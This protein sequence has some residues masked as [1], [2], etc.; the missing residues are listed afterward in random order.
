MSW[1]DIV[2]NNASKLIRLAQDNMD[3]FDEDEKKLIGFYIKS[4]ENKFDKGRFEALKFE[5]GRKGLLRRG[6]PDYGTYQE[7]KERW[8]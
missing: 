7:R 5:L 1:Q 3:K 6:S 2:K 8:G 4:L